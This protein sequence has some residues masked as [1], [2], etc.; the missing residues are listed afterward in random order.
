M[1]TLLTRIDEETYSP[2][3]QDSD[4]SPAKRQFNQKQ[5]QPL[6]LLVEEEEE[7]DY[8]SKGNSQNSYT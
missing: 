1:A 7:E 4:E 5:A 6:P 2:S 3:N 8:E